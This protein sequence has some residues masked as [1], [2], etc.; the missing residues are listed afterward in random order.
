MLAIGDV[1]AAPSAQL[2]FVAMIEVLQPMQVVQVP[3]DR[4]VLAV[5]LERVQRLVSARVARRL[6]GGER[7]VVE[8]RQEQAGVVDPDRLDLA[9]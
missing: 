3:H 1:Q 2:A 8:A 5:D 7:A 9:R 4:R 6:E